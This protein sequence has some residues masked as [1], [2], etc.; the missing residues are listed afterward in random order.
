[1]KK[2]ILICALMS[3]VIKSFAVSNNQ[4][5]N[6]NQPIIVLGEMNDQSAGAESYIHQAPAKLK[7]VIQEQSKISAAYDQKQQ[8]IVEEEDYFDDMNM[9]YGMFGEP[10]GGYGFNNMDVGPS[11][12]IP[13]SSTNSN[14]STN[15]K[16]P[17]NPLYE[18]QLKNGDIL[19]KQ[20]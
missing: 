19:F 17:I 8:E 12:V 11:I 6:N 15:Q 13:I 2:F 10:F 16:P 18:S 5:S 14:N 1:M 4:E 3:L 7:Q 9:G 20:Y